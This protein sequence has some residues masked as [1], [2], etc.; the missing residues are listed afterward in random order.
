MTSVTVQRWISNNQRDLYCKFLKP[1][2]DQQC[3]W[4]LYEID[5]LMFD[6]T[7]TVKENESLVKE[8]YGENLPKVGIPQFNRGRAAFEGEEI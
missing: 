8:K 4:L 7:L 6:G 2:M 5:D 1:L 3:G